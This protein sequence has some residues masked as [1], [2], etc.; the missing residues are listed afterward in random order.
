MRLALF[1]A[2]ALLAAGTTQARQLPPPDNHPPQEVALVGD[3]RPMRPAT[4]EHDASSVIHG[5]TVKEPYHWL[6]NPDDPAVQRWIKAQNAYTES[7]LAAM[8]AGKALTARVQKLA[9]T[10]TT[11][12]GPILADGTLFYLQQTPPQPQPVLIAQAWPDG[13]AKT[14]VNPNG[15]HGSR[16]ASVWALATSITCS[17]VSSS[18]PSAVP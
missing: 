17:V 8:P 12:S 10:S 18:P 3:G 2:T 16:S 13:K 7:E 9:I 4:P 11:R 1:V 6:E 14:L 5:V 15:D